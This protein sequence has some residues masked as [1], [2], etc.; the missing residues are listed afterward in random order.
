ME[1]GNVS[2][3]CKNNYPIM[4]IGVVICVFGI[5]LRAAAEVKMEAN[6]S[7]VIRKEKSGSHQLVTTGVY[8]FFR[9]PSYTGWFY[10]CIGREVLLMNPINFLISMF[11]NWFLLYY[12]IPYE[13]KY[14][15]SFFPEYDSYRKRTHIFIPFIPSVDMK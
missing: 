5:I 15:L 1:S 6:F 8:A 11:L 12:R 10:Y 9:H 14:L 3:R 2:S 13:E 4:N 7:H